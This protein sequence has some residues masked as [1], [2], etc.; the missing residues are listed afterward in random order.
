MPSGERALCDA[1]ELTRAD[2]A[3][4]LGGCGRQFQNPAWDGGSQ[5]TVGEALAQGP[6]KESI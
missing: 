4:H 1:P 5:A 6:K 3:P 2:T